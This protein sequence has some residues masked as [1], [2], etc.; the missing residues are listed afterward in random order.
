[1]IGCNNC[2]VNIHAKIILFHFKHGS[3]LKLECG[4]MLNVMAA[5]SN[6][7][8]ALSSAPQFC[9]RPLLECRNAAKTRNLLKFAEVP[10]TRQQISA[11]SGLKF[12]ILWG[13]MEEVLLFNKFFYDCRYVPS[14]RRYSPTKLCDG[15]QMAIFLRRVFSV[16]R[17]QHISDLHSKFTL[18]PHHVCKYGRHP[19]CDRWDWVRKKKKKGR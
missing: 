11:V 4:I 17:M 8:G 9:R 12:T 2:L 13:H 19:I 15:A 14:L 16:S 5:L 1:M 3:M 6:I 18:R 7:G 10:Q